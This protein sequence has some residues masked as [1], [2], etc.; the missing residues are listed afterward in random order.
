[1]RQGKDVNGWE[2]VSLADV[3]CNKEMEARVKMELQVSGNKSKTLGT[4]VSILTC[5]AT[6]M[7]SFTK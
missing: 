1:M 5:Q 6:P 3:I 2:Q 7:R 4:E